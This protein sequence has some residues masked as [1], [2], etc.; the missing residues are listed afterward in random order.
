MPVEERFSAPVQTGPGADPASYIMGT[1]TFQGI[2]RPER[3][4]DPTHLAPRIKSRAIP[5][6]H[7]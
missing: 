7:L 3:G 5:L 4:V 1:G 2:K 6:L